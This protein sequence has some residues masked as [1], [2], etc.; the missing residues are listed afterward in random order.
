M[1]NVWLRLWPLRPIQGVSLLLFPWVK[2]LVKDG[3]FRVA[4]CYLG[5]LGGDGDVV[6]SG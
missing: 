4:R 5:H 6:D 1:P 3:A 2:V